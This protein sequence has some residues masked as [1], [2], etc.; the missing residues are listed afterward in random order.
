MPAKASARKSI[1]TYCY[2]CVAGPDFMCVT[3]EDGVAVAVEPNHAGKGIHPADGRPCVKAYGLIQKTYNPNRVLTPMKR[4]N[5]S[6]GKD[7]DPG[8]VPI[9]WDEAL[10]LVAARLNGIRERGLL[11]EQGLPRVA[12]TFGHGGTPA[13]YMGTLPAFLAAWGPID[14]SLGS[15]Q[16]VKCTHS[17]HLYG[18]FWHRA[19]TVCADTTN[20]RYIVSFGAN[21]EV[22]G[23]VCAVRRHADARIRGVKRVHVEPH[24]SVTA[25]CSAEWVPI[26]PKTDP[27]FM[28]GMLHVLLSEVPLDRLDVPFLRD[29]TAAPYLVA[30]NGY[31]LRDPET[32][33]PLMWDTL[34][35][36][37][38]P[39]DHPGAVPALDGTYTVAAAI[40]HGPDGEVERFE[41]VAAHPSFA[42]MVEAMRPYTPEWAAA[43]CDVP[44]A[45]IRRVALEYLD[46]ACVGETVE[47]DGQILPFRPVAVTL[48]K[49][50]NNGWGAFECC[51]GRTVLATIVGALEVPGGTLGTTVR[52]NR[53]HDN[54]LATVKP[55]EDG[56][57]TC[58]FNPTTPDKW[59]GKPTGRNAHRTLVPHVGN[60]PW[61]QA[62]GPTH[63]AWMFMRESPENW[64]KP[65]MPEVW[66]AYRTNPAI[67]FWEIERLAETISQM[68]YIVAF[69]YTMDE[70][71]HMA[72]ILLPEAT[73]LEGTQLIRVGGTKFV[74]QHWDHRGVV[75][76]Q[77]V[78][79]P[80]G[81]AR[82]FTWIATELSRR[83][84]LLPEYVERINRG[85]ALVPLKG[86]GYDFSLPTDRF[87]ETDSIWDAACKAATFEMTGGKEVKDLEWMKAN[88]FFVVPFARA[89]WY[90]YPTMVE[91]G[92]RFELPYQ[93]RLLKIGEELKRR[94]HS[95][96]IHWWDTQLTEYRALPHW[97]DVPG[98]WVDALRNAG[99][100]PGEYPYWGITTK[101]M[102][103]STG[104]NSGIPLMNEVASNMRG[105]GRII[106]NAGTAKRLGINDGGW[107]EVASPVGATRGKAA[108][109]QG[110]R[111]DTIV[112]PGQ[113][114][115]WKTPYAKDLGYPSLNAVSSMSGMAL[116]L[117]DA[118]GS[119]ADVVRVRLR[120]VDGP[121]NEEQAS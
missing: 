95:Q 57:M 87:P 20:T 62:L 31:Y 75:L 33:K 121:L 34:T 101:S 23:G 73:D 45:T 46:N 4:T 50:V 32:A 67:S 44:A 79:E 26:K 113:F 102:Q 64:P 28:F 115:H 78:T 80:Q 96:G 114:Q 71:N 14:Y 24:L 111:P 69:A 83:V 97:D 92:L 6:K 5:P 107:V 86:E 65:T 117:T 82:D 66:F 19:F 72:D 88:G 81:E 68:P 63:L 41:S 13:S 56:F 15:G 59:I 70:T 55:G 18:E 2:N 91:Q 119:G 110:C 42:A 109:V 16:G 30:P 118:T 47:I 112:I 103:Y 38:V 25:G 39:F 74:E 17:E 89:D 77:P 53:P 54:R 11:D 108:V 85:A 43:V 40:T 8:F 37:A 94:L 1:P 90:L 98:H 10:D 7:Q 104:S 116:E 22:T 21:V 58:N 93:E 29:R 9:S 61:S 100:D 99:E 106:I 49:T 51:W 76:R 12:A 27:A 105:H 120:P 48:G 60:G 52:I 3:V 84:G 36:A 35:G